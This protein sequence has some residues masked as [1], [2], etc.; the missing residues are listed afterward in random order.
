MTALD[1]LNETRFS[2][3]LRQIAERSRRAFTKFF[4]FVYK[5]VLLKLVCNNGNRRF[6]RRFPFF[7]CFLF[8]FFSPSESL[9][10]IIEYA[11]LG[12]SS[13]A[14]VPEPDTF[15]PGYDIRLR[16]QLLSAR[17]QSGILP[18]FP[19]FCLF[20]P[21]V[22]H[23]SQPQTIRHRVRKLEFSPFI[24]CSSNRWQRVGIVQIIWFIHISEFLNQVIFNVLRQQ[25]SLHNSSV[26]LA[27]NWDEE[28]I[29][30]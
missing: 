21:Y 19:S 29:K 26:F 12:F 1:R 28:T 14:G 3:F 10:W 4:L 9:L 8:F 2:A 17:G 20:R 16:P 23:L 11:E 15:V 13:V 22:D 25:K 7:F 24:R 6:H 30:G 18:Q 27:N 5:M